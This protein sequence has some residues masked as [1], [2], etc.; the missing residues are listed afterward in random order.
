MKN[1]KIERKNPKMMISQK[2]KSFQAAFS[3]SEGPIKGRQG[4]A[5][6]FK[7]WVRTSALGRE[8][9]L[10]MRE[11]VNV[12]R[13]E[14]QHCNDDD[15]HKNK[16]PLRASMDLSDDYVVEEHDDNDYYMFNFDG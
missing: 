4:G 9:K 10:K 12:S 1:L 13:G 6:P 8:G 16:H 7:R 5:R 14:S 2:L 15:A 3:G 11:C